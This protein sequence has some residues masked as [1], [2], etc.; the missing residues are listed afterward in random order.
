MTKVLPSTGEVE[1]T[2]MD[3]ARVQVATTGQ[4]MVKLL[5]CT[6]CGVLLWDIDAH[7]AHAHP[8]TSDS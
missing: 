8:Q 7:Y 3:P 5:A 1:E 4:P 6:K 2:D